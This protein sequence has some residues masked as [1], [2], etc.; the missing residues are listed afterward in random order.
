MKEIQDRIDKALDCLGSA[1]YNLEGGY[2]DAAANRAYYA[3]F[4]AMLAIL[5]Y[6]GFQPKSHTGARTLFAQHFILTGDLPREMSL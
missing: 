5:L 1:Q 2:F 6:K 4:D 3:V